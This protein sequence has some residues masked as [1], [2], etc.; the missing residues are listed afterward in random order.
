MFDV[1]V[2]VTGVAWVLRILWADAGMRGCAGSGSRR[3]RTKFMTEDDGATRAVDN[4]QSGVTVIT[5]GGVVHRFR[6]GL[7]HPARSAVRMPQWTGECWRPRSPW[8]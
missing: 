4:F 1:I 3:Q 5:V 7:W 8:R 2:D 6:A